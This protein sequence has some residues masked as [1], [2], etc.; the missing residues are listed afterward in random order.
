MG[1]RWLFQKQ[2]LASIRLKRA[3]SW[4]EAVIEYK[5]YWKA[6]N[7]GEV[8]KGIKDLREYYGILQGK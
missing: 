7:S 1:I 4:E 3:A 8:P 6:I 2:K 5:A